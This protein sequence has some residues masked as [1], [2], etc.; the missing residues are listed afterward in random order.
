MCMLLPPQ[1]ETPQQN[2][3]ETMMRDGVDIEFY[4]LPRSSLKHSLSNGYGSQRGSEQTTPVQDKSLSNTQAAG[5]SGLSQPPPAKISRNMMEESINVLKTSPP[6]CSIETPSTSHGVLSGHQNNHLGSQRNS[7]PILPKLSN[8][9]TDTIE[10][11]NRSTG[12]HPPKKPEEENPLQ[13]PC[14][15]QTKSP[16]ECNGLSPKRPHMRGFPEVY[17]E[18]VLW[19]DS[20]IR[21]QAE[22]PRCVRFPRYIYAPHRATVGHLIEYLMVRAE[23]E[24]DWK[25]RLKYCIEITYVE[26]EPNK[27]GVNVDRSNN[28]IICSYPELSSEGRC[29]L[30]IQNIEH[31][32]RIMLRTAHPFQPLRHDLTMAELANT[33]HINYKNR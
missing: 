27:I 6:W 7:L 10:D 29:Q 18:L 2:A 5:S 19:P 20:S 9:A 3:L 21:R 32:Y 23:V 17:V 22:L 15:S 4:K 30:I 31:N 11:F 33:Y 25:D 8:N 28:G 26:D 14:T 16:Q 1:I 13:Q 12:A 24:A